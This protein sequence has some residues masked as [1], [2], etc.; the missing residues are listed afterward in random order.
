MNI[1]TYTTLIGP[2]IKEIRQQL[3]TGT[4]LKMLQKKT[5]LKSIKIRLLLGQ[6]FAILM[7]MG[8]ICR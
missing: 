1:H 3:F 5:Y 7:G 6:L 8:G 2:P 4:L